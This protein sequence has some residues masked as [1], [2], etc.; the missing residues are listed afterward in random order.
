MSKKEKKKEKPKES[1]AIAKIE[2]QVNLRIDERVSEQTIRDYLFGSQTKLT[3][4]QQKLFIMTAVTCNL[5]PI[6]REIYAVPYAEKD[7]AGNKTGQ[8]RLSI[9]TG[10]EVYLKRAERSGKL[11]GW[12]AWSEGEGTSLKAC[13]RIYRKDF[14]NP[15]YHEVFFTEY[16]Q[17]NK[18]WKYKPR[19][20]LKKV[21][22][23]QGF[24]LAFP[25]EIQGMPYTIE[26]SNVEQAIE[27]EG[28][29]VPALE[30]KVEQESKPET[31]HTPIPASHS[32]PAQ[33]PSPA[34]KPKAEGK[35]ELLNLVITEH[36]TIP[37]GTHKGKEYISLPANYLEWL[38]D[39]VT[40]PEDIDILLEV[41][42]DTLADT[43]MAK[44]EWTP[45]QLNGFITK[46]IKKSHWG[47]LSYSEKKTINLLLDGELKKIEV[48]K[49]GK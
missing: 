21:V 19:T 44:L 38:K 8:Y 18:M 15:F 29:D 43:Y 33:A 27:Y 11:A 7:D 31:A 12:E 40:K 3:E 37:F 16:N 47:Q 35:P 23:S 32:T 26:E 25:E 6:K 13:I 48:K 42:M 5:N 46:A 41:K 30:S 20:M 14:K 17:I 2:P 49:D 24:R 9:M 4:E 45:I 34:E 36:G 10:Y 1:K 22:I 39:R 28:K